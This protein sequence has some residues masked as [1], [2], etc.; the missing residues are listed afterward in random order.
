MHRNPLILF[1]D[2]CFFTTRARGNYSFFKLS[3]FRVKQLAWGG[4]LVGIRRL[5]W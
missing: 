5:S 4:L 2:V 3:R 1:R